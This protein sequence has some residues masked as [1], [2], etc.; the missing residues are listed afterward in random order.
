MQARGVPTTMRAS[1]G[2]RDLKDFDELGRDAA[3]DR[4]SLGRDGPFRGAPEATRHSY[5]LQNVNK[6]PQL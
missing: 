1:H 5:P 6:A 4:D 2:D 3:N